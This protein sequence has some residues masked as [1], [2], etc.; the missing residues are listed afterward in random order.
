[1]KRLEREQKIAF[2]RI[3]T[4]LIEADFVVEPEEMSFF[5]NII[6]KEQ[7]SITETMLIEAKKT[8]FAKALSTLQSLDIESRTT[9]VDTLKRLSMS[10]GVCVPLEAI[11]IFAVEQVLMHN[12]KIHSIP[13]PDIEI[14]NHKIIYVE[15]EES[16]AGKLI[17]KE[18]QQISDRLIDAGFDFVY[19]PHLVKDFRRMEREYLEKVIKYMLPSLQQER[20]SA[21]SN[22]LREITTAKFSRDLLYKKLGIELINCKPSLLIKIND[23]DIINGYNY[24]ATEVISF[25]HFLQLELND[26]IVGHIETLTRE[27]RTYLSNPT[28]AGNRPTSNKFIYTGFHRTLFNLIA[29]EREQ[30]EFRLIFE[31]NE[32][33]ADV[34]FE[35]TNDGKERIL[36]KLNP[37]ETA[38]YYLIVKK[39][40]SSNGLDWREHIPSAEKRL[41][42]DEYNHIYR[43]KGKANTASEY[44]DRTQVHHIRNRIRAIQCISNIEIFIPKHDKQGNVSI[45]RIY[46]NEKFVEIRDNTTL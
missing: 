42:L 36:L 25:S 11:L 8:D 38:L 7:L 3:I 9:I 21:I 40:L 20:I 17:E 2:T 13:K 28:K 32:N 39:S 16:E 24:D 46:A 4:D 35:A 26:D 29:F 5:E 37:Q 45:Y 30:K 43:K 31:I 44:K 1:M 12:A 10:D 23:S 19:I 34:Y 14:E 27:Y 22:N 41:L 18:I 15:D 33:R 6:S